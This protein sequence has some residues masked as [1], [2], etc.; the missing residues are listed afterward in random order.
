MMTDPSKENRPGQV[1]EKSII[2]VAETR[3]GSNYLC[4]LMEKTGKLGNP[5][6][7]FSPHINYEN[8]NTI[9]ER[10]QVALEEGI[11]DNGV[12]SV[13]LFAY[14]MDFIKG[15][16]QKLSDFFPNRYWIWLR[17]KDLLAQA[18]S[19]SI[20][21]Q[22]KSWHS[23]TE[24]TG[25]PVYSAK[26]IKRALKYIAIA[27]ARWNLF[28]ICNNISPL[29]LWYE[30]LVSNPEDMIMQIGSLAGIDINAEDINKDV[31]TSIQRTELNEEWRNRFLADSRNEDHLDELW[32][33]NN[34]KRTF[35]N[36]WKFITGSLARP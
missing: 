16:N 24:F 35:T 2:V 23:N 10:F 34:Y 11:T 26:K 5:Q 21:L 32:L 31:H 6:E 25:S 19:R 1:P 4:A 18:V 22:T 14:H 8:A 13:K 12:L 7:Y 33:R 29:L 20:A 28:F 36:F 17:R 9:A 3:T 27:E 30:D 15:E